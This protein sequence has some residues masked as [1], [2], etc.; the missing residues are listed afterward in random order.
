MIRYIV[1]SFFITVLTFASG[2]ATPEQGSRSISL[3]NAYTAI[4]DDPSAIF[5]NPAGL[6]Q[7]S[8][9]NISFGATFLQ[10]SNSF[11]ADGNKTSTIDQTFI[12][13]QLNASFKVH[14]KLTLGLG[15]SA[16][17]AIGIEWPDAWEGAELIEKMSLQVINI[18]PA[19]AFEIIP[20][21]HIGLTYDLGIAA[22]ELRKRTALGNDWIIANMGSDD[23]AIAHGFKVG[24]HYTLDNFRTGLV[25]RYGQEL[26]I[27]GSADFD[28]TNDAFLGSKPKDQKMKTTITLPNFIA[29]GVAYQL[30]SFLLTLDVQYTMWSSYDALTLEFEEGIASSE[31]ITKEVTTEK[32]W[33]NSFSFRV[34]M[35]YDTKAILPGLKLRLGYAYDLT[36]IPDET[37]DPSLPGSNRHLINVGIGYRPISW[38]QFDLA[39]SYLIFEERESNNEHLQGTYNGNV[40]IFGITSTLMF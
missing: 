31:G 10:P 35:E 40:Q 20:N 22:V 6:N 7:M 33:E 24:L 25:F 4:S 23:Y 3:G 12:M 17:Y 2:F 16:P 21:L 13:P 19:V 1:L 28:V 8:G 36:P 9:L 11:E 39:Y 30:S 15:I 29:W 26:N 32:D 37:V 5:Y 18:S 14:K 34:G 38:I 27:E